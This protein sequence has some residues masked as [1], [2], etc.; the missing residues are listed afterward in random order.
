M[1]SSDDQDRVSDEEEMALI[2]DES[3]SFYSHNFLPLRRNSVDLP[4]IYVV[5]YIKG[6]YFRE[7]YGSTSTDD[8]MTSVCLPL[9]STFMD[10][11][12]MSP[13]EPKPN[14]ISSFRLGSQKIWGK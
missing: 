1:N 2:G 8:K 14:T 11:K 4:L 13:A 12:I 10:E 5:L 9:A 7:N 3:L 6:P